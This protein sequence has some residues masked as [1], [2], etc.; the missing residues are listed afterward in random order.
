MEL[1]TILSR[2]DH[3]LLAVNATWEQIRAVCDDG[4]RY[5]TASVCIPPAFVRQAKAYVGD[6]LPVCTVIGFPNGYGTTASKVFEARDAIENGA[7]MFFMLSYQNTSELKENFRLSKY[8]SVSYDIW[9]DDVNKYYDTLN[10]ALKDLQTSYI[11]D[12]EFLD[13]ERVPDEDEVEAD[14]AA[15]AL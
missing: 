11:V 10:G 3:T 9:K 15:K 1:A 14:A 7:A 4:L 8:Y 2:C 12:H 13:G 5:H 6:R